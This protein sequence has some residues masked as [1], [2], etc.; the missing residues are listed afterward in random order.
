MRNRIVFRFSSKALSGVL[1]M[2]AFAAAVAAVTAFTAASIQKSH[3]GNTRAGVFPLEP[4]S[5]QHPPQ[6]PVAEPMVLVF[7]D[8]FEG[9]SL[10]W[11][12]WKSQR[13][14]D[15]TKRQTA[16]GPG[17]IDVRD[18]RL[19]LHVRK[20]SLDL[21]PNRSNLWTAGFVYIKEP[22]P[23]NV[24]IESRIKPSASPGVNNAFWL[25]VMTEERTSWSDRYEIDIVETR[26]LEEEPE[27]GRAHLAW[28]DWKTRAYALNRDNR[29]DHIAQGFGLRH[30]WDEYGVW[31]LW[32]GENE[33]I[34]YFNGEEVWRGTTHTRYHE[35]WETGVGKLDRWFPDEQVR[36]YGRFCQ[37]TWR[38]YGGYTGDRMNVIFSTLPWEAVWSPLTD[39]ADGTWMSVDYL[40]VYRPE[41]LVSREPIAVRDFSRS[42]ADPVLRLDEPLPLEEAAPL[43]AALHFHR[44]PGGAVKLALDDESGSVLGTVSAASDGSLALTLGEGDA[45]S[46][47]SWPA[48][49]RLRLPD[50]G[51]E[52]LVL[53]LRLT[54]NRDGTAPLLSAALFPATEVPREE[55]YLY[56]NVDAAGNTSW[57]QGWHL[58]C[59]ASVEGSWAS[60]RLVEAE[61]SAPVSLRVGRGFQSV[62]HR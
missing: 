45:S 3:A 54:P 24:Y 50:E 41:R 20:E 29:P 5:E 43:Y 40:R 31:G 9:D 21:G 57:N 15:G 6:N 18:G 49:E 36:A 46:I 37:D 47:L 17:N 38:Y 28:H 34:F 62:V 4:A 1:R 42:G 32:Y 60:L 33:F 16:R 52:D 44:Q 39:E 51:V 19:R 53:V 11:D 27:S 10:D 58:A 35:Q 14:E 2:T 61:K 25:G 23:N 59:K 13:Y 30:R 22:L 55:P 26:R 12:I 56:H 8:E 7:E 48:R